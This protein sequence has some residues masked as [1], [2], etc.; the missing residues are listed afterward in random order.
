[1]SFTFTGFEEKEMDI[2]EFESSLQ[3]DGFTDIKMS[4]LDQ[5]DNDEHVHPFELR[6]LVT[7]GELT[8][9]ISGTRRSY[10]EGEVFILPFECRHKETVGP[11]GVRYLMGKRYA[12]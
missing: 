9:T 12:A 4:G 1:M 6:A 3:R 2:K 11:E 10:R 8:L 7:A 5:R